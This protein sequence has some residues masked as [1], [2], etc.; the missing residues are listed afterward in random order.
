M[1]PHSLF[2][3][4]IFSEI[5]VVREIVLFCCAALLI[6]TYAKLTTRGTVFFEGQSSS[7]CTVIAIHKTQT[8]ES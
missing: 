4:Q 8:T 6:V 7:E 1:H 5:L 3:T 2:F